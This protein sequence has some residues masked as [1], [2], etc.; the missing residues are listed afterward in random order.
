[1]ITSGS[2]RDVG[3]DNC[4]FNQ[5]IMCPGGGD[6]SVRGKGW[7]CLACGECGWNPDVQKVRVRKWHEKNA[8]K[9]F[10]ELVARVRRHGR[11]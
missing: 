3:K 6:P 1:M 9:D 11:R 5:G 10:S 4:I 8:D 7:K 2:I